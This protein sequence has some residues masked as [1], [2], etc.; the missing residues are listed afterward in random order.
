[1]IVGFSGILG[2]VLAEF[3]VKNKEDYLI[4]Y[5]S[6]SVF[7]IISLVTCFLFKEEKFIMMDDNQKKVY[8]NNS[9]NDSAKLRDSTNC[10]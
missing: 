9:S 8:N 4:L 3:V 10:E 6:C 7:C 5:L 2:A 1:V